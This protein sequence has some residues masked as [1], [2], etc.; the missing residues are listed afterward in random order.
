MSLPLILL[1]FYF[2]LTHGRSWVFPGGGFVL[3]DSEI[4][5]SGEENTAAALVY[6]EMLLQSW[7]AREAAA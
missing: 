5:P 7:R 2:L 3:P 4:R 1:A 6:G